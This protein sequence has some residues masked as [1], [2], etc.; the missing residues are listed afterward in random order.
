MSGRWVPV[1][2]A[3]A[4][5]RAGSGTALRMHARPAPILDD[6]TAEDLRV[7]L[8]YAASRGSGSRPA[9]FDRIEA[10]LEAHDKTR[11]A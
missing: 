6:Q 9:A 5:S 8:L 1:D 3:I 4:F 10:V 2:T 7:L 11:E